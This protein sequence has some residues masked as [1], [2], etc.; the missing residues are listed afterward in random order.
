MADRGEIPIPVSDLVH[1]L[2]KSR[3][4]LRD[5]LRRFDRS[6][7]TMAQVLEQMQNERTFGDHTCFG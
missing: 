2:R 5:L 1:A 7:T 4:S 3:Y 6:E